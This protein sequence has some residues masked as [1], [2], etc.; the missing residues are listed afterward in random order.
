MN[1]LPG[2]GV[3]RAP[4][5]LGR[6]VGGQQQEDLGLQRIGVLEFVDEEMGEAR[7]KRPPHARMRREQIARAQQQIDE[8]ERAGAALER[9]VAVDDIAQL[10]VQQRGEI[11]VGGALKRVELAASAIRRRPTPR[12]AARRAVDAVA[13]AAWR[14]GSPGSAPDRS[15]RASQPSGSAA[16]K[17]SAVRPRG[18]TRGRRVS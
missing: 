7:L 9:F 15:T 2:T 1:S 5:A 18:S 12:R 10:V 3:M 4:V 17:R 13:A 8:V 6:I 16:S 11:A 14:G